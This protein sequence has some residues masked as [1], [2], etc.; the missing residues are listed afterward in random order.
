MDINILTY[1]NFD[2][3]NINYSKLININSSKKK[4]NIGYRE[5]DNL[6]IITPLFTNNIHYINLMNKI[7]FMKITFDPFIGP[8]YKF[9][10][11]LENI[12]NNIKLYIEKIKPKYTL[13]SIFKEEQNDVFDDDDDSDTDTNTNNDINNIDDILDSTVSSISSNIKYINLK[14]NHH[15]QNTNTNYDK[16]TKIYRE[17]ASECDISYLKNGSKY[18]CLINLDYIWFDINKKKF[19]LSIE[20]KQIKIYQP[21]YLSRC[22]I[23]NQISIQSYTQSNNS[24]SSND[25]STDYNIDYKID[26]KSSKQ[27][28]NTS[29]NGN[30][31]INNIKPIMIMPNPIELSNIKNALK[32]VLK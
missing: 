22:L 12:E 21:T 6:H 27:T 29:L 24:S 26:Y 25:E 15:E 13:H 10:Q 14:L 30:T 7:Q 32:K 20:I 9:Y 8:I 2:I 3:N 18:K 17:D 23:D 5:E 19:G 11:L 31:I 16:C 1:D 4:I 28:C